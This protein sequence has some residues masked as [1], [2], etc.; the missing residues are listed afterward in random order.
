MPYIRGSG[1]VTICSITIC[2]SSLNKEQKE[3]LENLEKLRMKVKLSI[4][5]F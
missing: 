1:Y 2:T 3:L 4:K 5:K